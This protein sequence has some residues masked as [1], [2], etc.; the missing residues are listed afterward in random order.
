M[1]WRWLST[2]GIAVVKAAN[3]VVPHSRYI[4]D[5]NLDIPENS[6]LAEQKEE[7]HLAQLKLYYLQNQEKYRLPGRTSAT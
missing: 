4:T 5:L 2:V 6:A 3:F 7:I 1:V